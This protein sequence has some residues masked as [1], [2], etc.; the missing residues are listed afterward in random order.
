MNEGTATAG[1]MRGQEG[2]LDSFENFSPSLE[3]SGAS[4][5]VRE[6]ISD[7]GPSKRASLHRLQK[8]ITLVPSLR[9]CQKFSVKPNR[10][11]IAYGGPSPRLVGLNSCGSSKCANCA[12]RKEA[13]HGGEIETILKRALEKK[14]TVVFA[15]LTAS[16]RG[17][18]ATSE[19]LS[20]FYECLHRLWDLSFGS[21]WWLAKRKGAWGGVGHIR[22]T[23]TQVRYEEG[24]EGF[25]PHIHAAFVFD[26]ELSDEEVKELSLLLE[27]RWV[28]CA[29]KRGL[30]ASMDAQEI[31]RA[32]N[33]DV[34]AYIAKG[35]ALELSRS[36]VKE[37]KGSASWLGLLGLIQEAEGTEDYERLVR[38]YRAFEIG[39]KGRR[40]V[41]ISG[42]LRELYGGEEATTE[43]VEV[44]V[45]A[46]AEGAAPDP[47]EEPIELS[48]EITSAL[49]RTKTKPE[50]LYLLRGREFVRSLREYAKQ[51]EELCD[52]ESWKA[53]IRGWLSEHLKTPHG[54][55][56]GIMSPDEVSEDFESP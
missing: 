54:L 37:G 9:D 52:V 44:E 29:P 16:N 7:V 31:K 34:A 55:P 10:G 48:A 56:R 14:G 15:T 6:A 46:E 2:L 40:A 4:G 8:K 32:S 50:L 5:T 1:L 28:E 17:Y 19:G 41:S 11:L 47:D 23:E 3:T 43:E 24:D 42:E 51:P 21:S 49:L 12:P 22:V 35:T 36:T 33:A 53:F 25:H 27:R 38:L 13:E 45:E 30:V 18:A 20:R 39:T 26:R